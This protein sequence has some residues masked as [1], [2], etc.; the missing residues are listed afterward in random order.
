MTASS[1]IASLNGSTMTS[2]PAE[3]AA[4]I[5]LSISVTRYP[6]RSC[7]KGNGIGVWNAKTD[8]VPAEVHK[9]WNSVLLGT[10]RTFVTD[11]LDG[12]P[13]NVAAKLLTNASKSPGATY[14]CVESYCAP[15][16]TPP[17]PGTL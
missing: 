2:A 13:P 7:P 12:W 11:S 5:A 10:G 17:S 1:P 8:R 15:T 9:Y 3:R 4:S 6:V 16:A 14:T